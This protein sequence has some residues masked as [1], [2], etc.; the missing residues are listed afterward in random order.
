M[1]GS[2]TR[3]GRLTG[4]RRRLRTVL[5]SLAVLLGTLGLVA[6][7]ED[8]SAQLRSCDEFTD[9][10]WDACFSINYQ[11]M[12]CTLVPLRE[13][14]AEG[15]FE[16]E[17]LPEWAITAE[18]NGAPIIFDIRAED[19]PV[20][21]GD[22]IGQLLEWAEERGL[23]LDYDEVDRCADSVSEGEIRESEGG[24]PETTEW[25]NYDDQASGR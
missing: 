2:Q 16:L 6:C 12:Y 11:E 19:A 22:A 13:Y 8:E 4:G 25:E 20:F 5:P 9:Q 17:E 10:Q 18:R 14:H 3:V 1:V 23:P 15:R 24:G 7:G 21:S